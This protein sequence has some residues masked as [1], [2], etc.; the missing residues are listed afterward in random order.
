MQFELHAALC[1]LVTLE[2][3]G[4]RVQVIADITLQ[5]MHLLSQNLLAESSGISTGS[6][7]DEQP[8]P[9]L[10]TATCGHTQQWYADHMTLMS[11]DSTLT[12]NPP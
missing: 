6:G 4:L 7:I 11:G 12:F 5:K 9:A 1:E 8:A 2:I 10:P 3:N